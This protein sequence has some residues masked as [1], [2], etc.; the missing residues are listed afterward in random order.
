MV[1]RI[2]IMR[3][4]LRHAEPRLCALRPHIVPRS[5][6]SALALMMM[7]NLMI[8]IPKLGHMTIRLN[9]HKRMHMIYTI[10]VRG[11]LP[12]RDVQ[13]VPSEIHTSAL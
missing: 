11:M 8:G 13:F 5:S 3:S 7:G 6:R 2:S 4:L 12:S 9:A 1:L 10:V